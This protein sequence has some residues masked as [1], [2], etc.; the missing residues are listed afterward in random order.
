[1]RLF[2]V[3]LKD[4]MRRKRRVLYATVGV[5]I[6]TMTVI[7]ILTIANAGQAKIYSQLEK[8]GANLSI[9]PA[10]KS[11]NTGLG[12]LTLGTV[13]IGENYISQ[14]KVP[15]IQRIA[16]YEIKNALDI[17][18]EGNVAIVAPKLFLA[19]EV[20]GA[21]VMLVGIEPVQEMA[22]RTWWEIKSGKVFDSADQ[23]LS[24]SMAAELLGLNVG[25]TINIK[26]RSLTIAGI[27]G[28]TGSNDDYQIF[29]P[30]ATL[31]GIF[32][33]QGLI[34]SI[35]VRALCNGC[36]VEVIAD[37]VN[38][39]IPGV[40]AV[41]VKQVADTE[42]GMVE[43]VNGFM[44][45]LA[46]VTLLVGGFGVVNTLMTSVNE[47][48]KDIGI[49]RAVGASR[50]QITVALVYEAIIIG[51]AG[52]ILGYGAGT[53]LSY[54]A[55]PLIFEGASISFVPVYLPLSLGLAI[56]IAV[57]ATLYPA[58]HAGKI[59]VADSFRSL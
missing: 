50:R 8:Y 26:D 38:L 55:G 32:D 25:D 37:A 16:D 31:Q 15:E 4:I 41:A 36:P 12:D 18:D 59:R 48:I 24:G 57:L 13:T 28:E 33:K 27:L 51:I 53:L 29:L 44:L 46:G 45:A 49:M 11:L 34:S 5:I 2:Q 47:R 7:S 54:F 43:K 10:T 22:I 35:D 9:V 21:S 3:V 17:K 20:K 6:G 30:L 19:G 1:M 39:E 58:L 52:G 40:R 14:D 56:L 42:M 23:V